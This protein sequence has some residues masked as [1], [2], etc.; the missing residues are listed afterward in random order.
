MTFFIHLFTLSRIHAYVKQDPAYLNGYGPQLAPILFNMVASN[1]NARKR[2]SEILKDPFFA[3]HV[4]ERYR[5]EGA[6]DRQTP[7]AVF[8]MEKMEEGEEKEE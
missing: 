1:P 8:S 3:E 7:A 6:Y 5:A 4:P 2:P